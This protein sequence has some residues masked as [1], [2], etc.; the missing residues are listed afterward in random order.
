M[1]IEYNWNCRT[2]DVHP[3]EGDE[4]NVVYNVHWEVTGI[5]S[6]LD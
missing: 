4:T 6:E 3:T 5:S 2:V 1:A